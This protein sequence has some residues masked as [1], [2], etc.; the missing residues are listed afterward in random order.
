MTDAMARD[1]RAD[2]QASLAKALPALLLAVVAALALALAGCGQPQTLEEYFDQN[3]DEWQAAQDA[4][5]ADSLTSDGTFTDVSMEVKGNN[6]QVTCT[7]PEKAETYTSAGVDW[8]SLWS[9]EDSAM[10]SGL[11]DIEDGSNISGITM[12]FAILG[13]DGNTVTSHTFGPVSS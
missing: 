6:I 7:L 10:E 12:T 5:D 11:K 1:E 13:S 4:F 8:D 2:A 9:S 3:P